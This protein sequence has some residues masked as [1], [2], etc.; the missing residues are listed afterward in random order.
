MEPVAT[1]IELFEHTLDKKALVLFQEHKGK[2]V[3]LTKL[4]TMFLQRC[5]PWRKTERDQLQSWN[6]LIVDP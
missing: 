5:N 4:K 2:F 1:V 3:D 6:I